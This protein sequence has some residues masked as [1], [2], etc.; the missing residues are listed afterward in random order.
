MLGRMRRLAAVVLFA[1]ACGPA[2]SRP[3]IDGLH[4][5]GSFL[6]NARGE[7]VQLRGVTRSGTEYGCVQGWGIHDGPVDAASFATIASWGANAVRVPLNES[8]WLALPGVDPALSGEPY[9][10]AIEDEVAQITSQGL[11]AILEL[12]WSSPDD[13]PALGQEPMPDRAHTP[14]FWSEVASRFAGEDRIAFEP[15]NEPYPDEDRASDA[16]W[17]CWQSGGTCAG[18]P[19]EAAGMQELVDAIRGAGARQLILLGGVQYANDLS[20]WVARA[21]SDPSHNLAAAWHVYRFNAC[22]DPSCYAWRVRPL[23][24]S[25]P[26][27]ATEVGEDDEQGAFIDGTMGWLDGVGQGYLGWVWN[28][29]PDSPYAL[30]QDWGGTPRGIYGAT[31]RDHYLGH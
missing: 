2:Q 12:H 10:Q 13:A 22:A 21:P 3:P 1:L 24:G 5:E 31:L 15:F 23:L 30:V 17:A 11:L 14:L 20:Q 28:V 19:F 6:L 16:A 9:Q 26:V 27:V 29:W 7:P 8:C 25:V 18:V 4:A